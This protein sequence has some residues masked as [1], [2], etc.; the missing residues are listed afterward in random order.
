MAGKSNSLAETYLNLVYKGTTDADLAGDAGT[1]D[2]IYFALHTGD[3]GDAGTQASNEVTAAQYPAYARVGVSRGS[4]FGNT[5]TSNG[6][7]AIH[8]TAPITFPTTDASGTGC[9]VTH[10]STGISASGATR[11]LHSGAI[12]PAMAIPAATAGVIPQLTTATVIQES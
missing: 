8:P 3:P 1:A 2:T 12:S 11:I 10:F 9:T 4:G 6:A 5:T 7:T